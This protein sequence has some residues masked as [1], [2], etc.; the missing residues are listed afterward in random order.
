MNNILLALRHRLDTWSLAMRFSKQNSVLKNYIFWDVTQYSLLK[1]NRSFGGTCRI[2]LQAWKTSQARNRRQASRAL[3]ATY[4]FDPEDR[5]DMFL[6]NVG[7]LSNGLNGV[8]S[9]ISLNTKLSYTA[10]DA[11]LLTR[12][13][14][15]PILLVHPSARAASF[16]WFLCSPFNYFFF[17]FHEAVF[18][19]DYIVYKLYIV[20]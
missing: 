14:P 7:W 3:L 19:S 18:R 4:I 1:V 17:V 13:Q 16:H 11:Y 6:R 2:H 15:S 9:H 10:L 8:I 5:G 12:I 20:M